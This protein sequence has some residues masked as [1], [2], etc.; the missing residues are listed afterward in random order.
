MKELI[1]DTCFKNGRCANQPSD[2]FYAIVNK[3]N[4]FGYPFNFENSP[5]YPNGNNLLQRWA[6]NKE[7][8]NDS[9]DKLRGLVNNPSCNNNI[10][11]NQSSENYS[12]R[13][14][15]IY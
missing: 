5:D 12:R 11:D 8:V 4:V 15:S 13:R 6:P 1:Y 2:K 10:N 3:L 7:G 9:Q 14:S